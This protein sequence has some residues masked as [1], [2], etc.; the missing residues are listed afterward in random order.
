MYFI[1]FYIGMGGR[2]RTHIYSFGDC[3]ST[4][5]LHPYFSYILPI[6]WPYQI[7]TDTK[8]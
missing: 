2:N 7:R 6:G 3:H 1:I 4:I 8:R 5:E